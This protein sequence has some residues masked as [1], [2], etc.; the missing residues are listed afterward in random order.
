MDYEW[1]LERLRSMCVRTGGPGPAGLSVLLVPLKNQQGVSM[2]KMTTSGGTASGSTY[3]ELEDVKVPVENLLG[4][5]G[6]GMRYIMTNFNHE[7]LNIAILVATQ[8]RVALS[9]AFEWVMK[10]EA[11][12]QPLIMQPVVRH[13]LAKAGAELESLWAWIESFAYQMSRMNKRDADAKLGGST[14]LAKA[15]AGLVLNECAQCAQLLFGGN[16]YTESGQGEVISRIAREIA[17]AR[18][19]G[20]S[21]DVLF[22]LAI[23]ELYKHYRRATQAKA[24][25]FFVYTECDINAAYSD[26]GNSV[27][28][29]LDTCMN[30][31]AEKGSDE[32]TD[33]CQAV[34]WNVAG[35]RC[36][37]KGRG[38]TAQNTTKSVGTIMAFSDP[39]VWANAKG[40]CG[41]NNNSIVTN[42]R[43]QQFQVLCDTRY[44]GDNY[45]STIRASYPAKHTET[46]EECLE[47]CSDGDPFCWGVL[48]SPTMEGGY[49]NCWAKNANATLHKGTWVPQ[50]NQ[51]TAYAYEAIN[52]T[53]AGSSYT[54][55]SGAVFNTSCDH[56]GDSPDLQRVHADSFEHCQDLCADYKPDSGNAACKGVVYQPSARDGWLNCY[57]K[58]GL[59]NITAQGE[60]HTAVLASSSSD[61]GSSS[62]SSKAW[63]AGPVV[64]GIAIIAIIAGVLF[65]RRR[66]SRRNYPQQ[67]S[68]ERVES[69]P[70]K[71]Q[72]PLQDNHAQHNSDGSPFLSPSAGGDS[73]Y[74]PAKYDYAPPTSRQTGPAEMSTG[75]T[76][77]AAELPTG[78]GPRHELPTS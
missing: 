39:T 15:R 27:M 45:D 1:A 5:E 34:A 44:K 57:L 69:E 70:F 68:Q 7:R 50:T 31:C 8:A 23:R 26:I 64:G 53:C 77:E 17:G 10:R 21:E 49:R 61:T 59:T 12:G 41:Y 16:G 40:G 9:L 38:I 48:F 30:A 43:E 13:R 71:Q 32:D 65:W 62:S 25:M 51:I 78:Q 14:A 33:P 58:Y 74:P 29:D 72:Y 75:S 47:Y 19:P 73:Y 4:R 42:T 3:I 52:T 6:Q 11:F 56:T 76:M 60:W 22:D 66:R 35:S 63:I 55:P 2:R 24:K 28:D 18:V 46:L 37:L 36:Y 67:S 20:G 54:T